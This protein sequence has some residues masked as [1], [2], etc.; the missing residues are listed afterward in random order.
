MIK[1]SQLM[2]LWYLSHRWP[3]KVQVS[4]YIWAVSPEPSLFAHMKYGSRRRVRQKIRHLAP[5]PLDGCACA[6]EEFVYGGRKV[7]YSHDMAQMV[8]TLPITYQQI[9]SRHARGLVHW[10]ACLC[11]GKLTASQ[12]HPCSVTHLGKTETFTTVNAENY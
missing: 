8:P 12:T 3:S 4:L 5:L 9:S 2:R 7:P 6:F 10:F 11:R 1:M